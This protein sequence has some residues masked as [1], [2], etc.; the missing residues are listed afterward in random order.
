MVVLAHYGCNS[1]NTTDDVLNPARGLPSFGE[2]R[3]WG[4]GIFTP[5]RIWT[6]FFFFPQER[7]WF[8]DWEAKSLKK[9]FCGARVVGFSK[10]AGLVKLTG[11]RGQ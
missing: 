1:T 5:D 4:R 6:P 9:G 3:P 11:Q 7:I 10:G 8:L 2:T